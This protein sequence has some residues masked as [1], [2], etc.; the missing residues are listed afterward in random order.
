MLRL[1][2]PVA[3]TTIEPSASRSISSVMATPLSIIIDAVLLIGLVNGY[4]CRYC[5]TV[6]YRYTYTIA[7]TFTYNG[8]GQAIDNLGGYAYSALQ[9]T[10]NGTNTATG[11]LQADVLIME[12]IITLACSNT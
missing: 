5:H 1:L 4:I 2:I 9:L 12:P 8:I 6:Q 3:L 10:G 7:G 11:T